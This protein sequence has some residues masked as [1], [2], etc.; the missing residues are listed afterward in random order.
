M[1][2]RRLGLERSCSLLKEVLW[3]ELRFERD[4]QL[5]ASMSFETLEFFGAAKLGSELLVLET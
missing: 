2:V 3:K 5:Q 4:H 1:R